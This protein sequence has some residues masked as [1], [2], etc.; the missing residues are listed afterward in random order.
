MTSQPSQPNMSD[1]LNWRMHWLAEKTLVSLLGGGLIAACAAAGSAITAE[2]YSALATDMPTHIG[3]T[4]G[5]A[6]P[7]AI[8]QVTGL[9]Q[10]TSVAPEGVQFADAF[11]VER[12]V[13]DGKHDVDGRVWAS[14]DLEI[15][16]WKVPA[17]FLFKHPATHY[18]ILTPGVDIPAPE[19]WQGRGGPI[20][21]GS[22]CFRSPASSCKVFYH[23]WYGKKYWTVVAQVAQDGV[24]LGEIANPNIG[25]RWIFDAHFALMKFGNF[26]HVNLVLDKVRNA[27]RGGLLWLFAAAGLLLPQLAAFSYARAPLS[28][29]WLLVGLLRV[30]IVVVPLAV[31]QVPVPAP[32]G[33]VTTL[34]WS[35]VALAGFVAQFF[36]P[37]KPAPALA[38][39][40]S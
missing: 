34:C 2:D 6:H 38:R 32:Y 30:A 8:V 23:A 7:G 26:D 37:K 18:Y 16:G 12:L 11:K 25:A 39:S 15:R 10:F 22:T 27:R 24:S 5:D 17:Q 31:A 36:W 3:A 33:I 19:A 35:A 40:G 14:D 29:T 4:A 13:K 20:I 28:N 1:D 9:P 21:T